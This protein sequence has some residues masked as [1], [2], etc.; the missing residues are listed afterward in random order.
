[1]TTKILKLDYHQNNVASLMGE[2][3]IKINEIIK[4]FNK[5]EEKVNAMQKE[6][7]RSL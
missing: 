3:I 6:G 5:L 7:S 1:M 2:I 4:R